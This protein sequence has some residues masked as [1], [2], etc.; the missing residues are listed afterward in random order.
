MLNIICKDGEFF[1]KG[2]IDL[3]ITGIHTN[4]TFDDDMI[5]IM[6]C[7]YDELCTALE[8]GDDFFFEPILPYLQKAE[9]SEE[10]FAKA[11]ESYYN[12][13]LEELQK[14]IKEIN[15]CIWIHLFEDLVGCEY[16]FWE[17]EEA[18]CPEYVDKYDEAYYSELYG[19]HSQRIYEMY[20][21]FYDLP[22]N[23][24]MAKPDVEAE[25]R[26]MFP[27]FNFDGLIE[28][29]IPE[30]ISLNGKYMSFQ[31]SDNWGAELLCSAYDELDEDFKFTDWHNH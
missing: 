21:A 10:G 3:G 5:S 4:D 2:S 12:N 25:L 9:K 19:K 13:K 27:M 26:E 23:G 8:T 31:C 28:T 22:N 11:L 15:D 17:I 7:S 14:N 6:Y 24:T 20:D 30:G 1:A 18:I 29:I 16:P